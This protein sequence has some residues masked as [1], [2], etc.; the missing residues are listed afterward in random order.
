MEETKEEP[1]EDPEEEPSE[2][3][4]DPE[5]QQEKVIIMPTTKK[6]KIATLSNNI[7]Y[8]FNGI[9]MTYNEQKPTRNSVFKVGPVHHRESRPPSGS[10]AERKFY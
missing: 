1:S 6:K 2:P 3:S 9:S 8:K 5:E 7:T 10:D 4:E